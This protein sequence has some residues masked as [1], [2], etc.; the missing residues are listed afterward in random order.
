MRMNWWH[1]A[2]LTVGMTVLLGLRISVVASAA[3]PPSASDTSET[4]S[5][6]KAY[7]W[8]AD[9]LKSLLDRFVAAGR[10]SSV[11]AKDAALVEAAGRAYKRQRLGNEST[12]A[13]AQR[14]R[15]HRA[16]DHPPIPPEQELTALMRLLYLDAAKAAQ[17][18]AR[19][20]RRRED[21]EG[22]AARAQELLAAAKALGLRLELASP[23]MKE[24]LGLPPSVS[25][26]L[27]PLSHRGARVEVVLGELIVEKLT[28][29]K[30]VY[31]R[32]P[33]DALRTARG[34]LKEVYSALKQYDASAMMLG[35]YDPVWQKNRGHMLL[36]LPSD[37]PSIYLNE[38][39]RAG[40]EAGVRLV[41]LLALGPKGKLGELRFRLR[42]PRGRKSVRTVECPDEQPMSE[43][44][45]KLARAQGRSLVIY[46]G[47]RSTA[48]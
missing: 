20:A 33:T 11:E 26:G 1:R 42:R 37:V 32:P 6:Q 16:P 30:F 38:I 31:D 45:R 48:G 34:A 25:G 19:R 3:P 15:R 8:S 18:W 44:A 22:F 40:R 12:R 35:E 24:V 36:I 47:R 23:R 2:L 5:D 14:L 28:R 7:E 17:V 39:A 4:G 27:K 29:A 43:C 41:H 21:R 46:T 13:Y 10:L 9:T